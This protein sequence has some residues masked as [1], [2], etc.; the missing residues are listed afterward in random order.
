MHAT[1]SQTGIVVPPS[2]MAPPVVL[3]SRPVAPASG[4]L[5]SVP[6]VHA[7]VVIHA[8][9]ICDRPPQPNATAHTREDAAPH[10]SAC[11]V[12]PLDDSGAD[13]LWL[14]STGMTVGMALAGRK[15]S[16]LERVVGASLEALPSVTSLRRGL[17]QGR[18]SAR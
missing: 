1:P 11:N 10:R 6:I 3:E 14:A 12:E 4:M 2:G 15:S 5:E 9:S 8:G 18:C 16:A 17:R 7:S 13:A